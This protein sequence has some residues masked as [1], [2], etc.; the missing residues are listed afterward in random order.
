M[1]SIKMLMMLLKREKN[2]IIT[3][4]GGVDKSYMIK[5]LNENASGYYFNGGDYDLIHRNSFSVPL[6]R[7]YKTR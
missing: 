3:G 6:I 5:K 7:S 4:G 2:N 1:T